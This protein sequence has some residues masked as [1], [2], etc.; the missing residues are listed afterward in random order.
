[1]EKTGKYWKKVERNRNK[2]KVMERYG[3]NRR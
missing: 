3:T 2:W 1:M